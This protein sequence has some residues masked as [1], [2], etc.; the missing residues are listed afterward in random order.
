MVVEVHVERKAVVAVAAAADHH[1][2]S[3][4]LVG[5]GQQSWRAVSDR[6]TTQTLQHSPFAQLDRSVET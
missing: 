3:S 2:A 5:P 6:H 1:V 4:V